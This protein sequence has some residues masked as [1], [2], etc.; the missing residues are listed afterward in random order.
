MDAMDLDPP[1]PQRPQLQPQSQ[2]QQ[3]NPQTQPMASQSS[4]PS[5]RL[6]SYTQTH[7][8]PG[9]RYDPVHGAAENTWGSQQWQPV[10]P[11]ASPYYMHQRSQSGSDTFSSSSLGGPGQS[12]PPIAPPEPYAYQLPFGYQANMPNQPIA[13]PHTQSPQDPYY[14]PSPYMPMLHNG[15][16]PRLAPIHPAF[17]GMERMSMNLAQM[18]HQSFGGSQ[19][20]PTFPGSHANSLRPQPPS[21]QRPSRS[22]SHSST[23]NSAT[24]SAAAWQQTHRVNATVPPPPPPSSLLP[25]TNNHHQQHRMPHSSSRRY[26]PNTFRP[27]SMASNGDL[28]VSPPRSARGSFADEEDAVRDAQFV[29]GAMVSKSV[30]STAAIKSLQ[31]LDISS[32]PE[33]ERTCNICYN[34][35]GV[36]TPEG[37]TEVPIRIP[38]C[39]HVFGSNCIKTWFKDADHCPY[40]RAKVQSE[41]KYTLPSGS[42]QASAVLSQ[43]LSLMM[44][45]RAGHSLAQNHSLFNELMQQGILP[46]HLGNPPSFPDRRPPPTNGEDA[47]RRQRARHGSYSANQLRSQQ[48]QHPTLDEQV[49]RMH[50]MQYHL[51]EL[52]NQTQTPPTGSQPASHVDSAG[53]DNVQARQPTAPAAGGTNRPESQQLPGGSGVP[54]L[55]MMMNRGNPASWQPPWTAAT[56]GDVPENA[57]ALRGNAPAPRLASGLL[58]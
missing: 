34:D 4:C 35:F 37:V 50:Q 19:Q 3:P 17:R 18:Q 9:S 2:Q 12:H 24:G 25:G 56:T 57:D 46:D 38:G 10:H 41:R 33:T 58:P 51:S 31:K 22:N 6:D 8:S 52:R 26:R 13:G 20:S 48:Q 44:R 42:A 54:H 11:P 39:K 32:L 47:H 49:Q 21:Q 29:R 5:G 45:S 27:S 36:E 43:Q 28:S 23:N 53:G 55:S 15:G 16:P 30:A 1:E 7:I 40:C 14:V